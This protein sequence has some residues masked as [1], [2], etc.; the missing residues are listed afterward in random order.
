M[1]ATASSG[2]EALRATL[3]T[4]LRLRPERL[5]VRAVQKAA[6]DG[7]YLHHLMASKGEGVFLELLFA[8]AD[9]RPAPERPERL[10]A[11]ARQVVQAL[12]RSRLRFVGEA[13]RKARLAACMSCA[14]RQAPPDGGLQRL[15]RTRQVC[16]LCGCDVEKKTRLS[17]ETCPATPSRW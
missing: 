5:P 13:E 17:G 14:H 12:V 4:E 1:S 3:A 8:E 10:Q 15:L 11:Q 16:G 6:A 7:L 2:L 9:K